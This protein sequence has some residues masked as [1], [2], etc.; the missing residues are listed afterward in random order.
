VGLASA[1]PGGRGLAVASMPEA[2][3]VGKVDGRDEAPG[4]GN[5]GVRRTGPCNGGHAL[6]RQSAMVGIRRERAPELAEGF[7]PDASDFVRAGLLVGTARP[8][9]VPA[10]GRF[11]SDQGGV[12]RIVLVFDAPRL[13]YCRQI[14]GFIRW[15]F[16]NRHCYTYRVGFVYEHRVNA[17]RDT[18]FG[19]AAFV[20]KSRRL[21][22]DVYAVSSWDYI[23]YFEV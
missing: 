22:H 19:V 1:A 9:G 2:G 17:W 7:L 4:V 11:G 15:T 13:S 14:A 16:G 8:A 10:A 12:A 3:L 20:R 23:E 6:V 5:A 18:A 21:G